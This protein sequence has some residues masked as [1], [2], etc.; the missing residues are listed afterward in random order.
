[1]YDSPVGK[2]KISASNDG[3]FE[4]EFT[5]SDLIEDPR[6]EYFISQLDEYFYG[7]RKAFSVK[8]DIRGSDFQKRVYEIVSQIPFG[9]VMTYSDIAIMLGNKHLSRSVG[10]ALAKNPLMIVIPCHRVVRA[11]GIGGYAG[12]VWRK[13]WLLS[14]ERRWTN[15]G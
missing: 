6:L 14:H 7:D 4:I 10:N 12:G 8:F 9:E 3:I 13:R 5:D 2:I 1:M 15:P 11:D